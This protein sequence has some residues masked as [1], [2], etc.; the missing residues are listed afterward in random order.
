MLGR[1]FKSATELDRSPWNDLD[2]QRERDL[3][4]HALLSCAQSLP[5]ATSADDTLRLIAE[6]LLSCTPHLRAI[7]SWHGPAEADTVQPQV[8]C[9]PAREFAQA[10]STTRAALARSGA[11]LRMLAEPGEPGRITG[12]APFLPPTAPEARHGIKA[13]LAAALRLPD[14]SRSGLIALHADQAEYFERVGI[15]LFTAFA[16]FGEVALQLEQLHRVARAAANADPLTALLNRRGMQERLM[17]VVE[18][19]RAELATKLRRAHLLLIDIDYFK[20]VNEYYGQEAG[21]RLIVDMAR[22]FSQNLR[23]NDVISRWGGQEFLVV[24][25]NQ[26]DEVVR[27]VAERLRQAVTQHPFRVEHESLQ[28]S[29]SIGVAPYA[30]EWDTP[31]AWLAQA[32]TALQRAKQ[33]GR[34]RVCWAS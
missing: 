27:Q 11:A 5:T 25:V 13:S 16:R 12:A 4:C 19:Q 32:T 24:L 7:W 34:N 14:G 22:L 30:A 6:Q 21:D 18:Q 23:H 2:W 28:A 29:V 31:E 8:A 33:Q 17:Q 10:I 3:L 26:P 20:Q 9:G 1:L 15:D